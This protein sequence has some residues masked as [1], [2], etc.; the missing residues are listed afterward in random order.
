MKYVSRDEYILERV[1]NRKVLHL[2]CVGFADL[3]TDERIRLARQSL[4]FSLT[5]VAD[6]IGVD[7]SKDVVEYFR[8]EGVFDNIVVGNA[9]RL[10]ELEL[11]AR[12]DVIVAGDIIEHLSNPGLMLDGIHSLCR[13]DTDV[14]L[15][16]PHS[17]GLPNFLRHVSGRFHEG[18]EHVMCFNAQN[19]RNLLLRHA[20]DVVELHTCYQA[21]AKRSQLFAIGRTFFEL[22][23]F[24]GGTLLVV[25]RPARSNLRSP[26]EASA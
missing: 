2:G 7:Y 10:Q 12:F 23:P 25:A 1:Q 14:I 24:L 4:H 21:N 11:Q 5:S 20:F 16:T 15:S 13:P 9:E 3:D 6:C 19:L 18:A 26:R 17:F 22:M 8:R